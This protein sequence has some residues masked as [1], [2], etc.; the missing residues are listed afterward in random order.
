METYCTA[1]YNGNNEDQK[2]VG[3][4]MKHKAVYNPYLPCWEYIP[5][6][7]PHVFEGRVW[8][9]GSHDRPGGDRY[10]MEDYVVW[11]APEDDLTQWEC[12]GTIYK[13]ADDP[14]IPNGE[15]LMLAPDVAKGPDG[16]YYLYYF[17]SDIK[18][19]SVAVSDTP[20]GRFKYYG[21]IRYPDGR[22][23]D[24][25]SPFDPGILSDESGNWLYYGF[26]LARQSKRIP[27]GHLKGGY[28]VRLAD[29]MITICSKPAEVL[30]GA[31]AAKGT[32][33]E[34][35]GFLE[36][37]SIRHIRGRYYLVYSSEQGHELCYAVSDHPDSG[38]EYG[39]VII[40]NA[41]VGYRERT[42][43]V[44]Y[45]ANNHGGMVLIR[46]QWYIFYH[47]HTHQAQ[48]SRQGCAEKIVIDEQGKIRQVEVTS[49][50][51]NQGALPAEGRYPSYIICGLRGPEGVLHLSSSVHRR[52][53]D[54]YLI[55]ETRGDESG[56]YVENLRAGAVCTVKYLEF[57][58][59]EKRAGIK[60]RG[61][62]S[63]TVKILV[64]EKD[65]P[66]LWYPVSKIRINSKGESAAWK[67]VEAELES[68]KGVYTVYFEISGQGILE[69][70]EFSFLS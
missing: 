64:R 68:L 51:L 21:D 49:C 11:S 57:S 12:G 40:S 26:C 31:A 5:D 13:K 33:Y 63:G 52:E 54:P 38:F 4:Q 61:G 2:K 7:E 15:K 47:R 70:K 66:G 69:W 22:L 16:R 9:Y 60:Y 67:T 17:L 24:G 27:G 50:G 18:K 42:D 48:Y 34:G 28:C 41:D 8:V 55:E 53:S 45:M 20:G 36:A 56:M 62:F 65:D 35:H 19:I 44:N 32:P 30:P 46:D 39:G 10:C 29:D 1:G 37:S 59:K 43:P 23:L 14:G 25:G 3:G 6:G 58:G